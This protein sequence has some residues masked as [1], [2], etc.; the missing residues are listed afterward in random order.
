MVMVETAIA[1]EQSLLET[2]DAIAIAMNLSRNQVLA[3]ALTEFVQQ[4]QQRQSLTLATINT[5]YADAPDPDD[6]RLLKGMRRLQRHILE[7]DP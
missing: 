6:E 5:A 1:L 3:M 4:H 2:A 7:N